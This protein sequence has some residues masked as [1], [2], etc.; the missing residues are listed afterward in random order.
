MYLLG[1][2]EHHNYIPAVLASDEPHF[3]AANKIRSDGFSGRGNVLQG[4]RSRCGRFDDFDK[5]ST[6]N[7]AFR[8]RVES[9]EKLGLRQCLL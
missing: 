9:R 8:L 5:A 2:L 3:R 4:N 1:V 7:A 6:C